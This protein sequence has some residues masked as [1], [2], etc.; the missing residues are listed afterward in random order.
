MR[1]D[2]FSV[3]GRGQKTRNG[4]RESLLLLSSLSGRR[5]GIAGSRAFFPSHVGRGG[6]GRCSRRVDA[7]AT[8]WPRLGPLLG[9]CVFGT[10]VSIAT[11]DS[12][13]TSSAFRLY[14]A[15]EENSL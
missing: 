1:G 7:V 12:E 4:K 8:S 6:R 11:L 13:F 15:K 5:V 14:N 3:G 9:R 2:R 10:S